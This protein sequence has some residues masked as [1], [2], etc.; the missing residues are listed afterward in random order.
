MQDTHSLD[1]ESALSGPIR[2]VTK[3]G[4][5]AMVNVSP[6]RVSQMIKAG[7]PVEHNGRIDIAR[8]KL[9]IAENISNTRS[10]A[11]VRGPDLF[12]EDRRKISLNDERS[13]LAKEQ[14]DAVAMRNEQL[15]RELVKASDVE[16]EWASILRKLRSSLLAVPSRTRQLLA[17]LTPHDVAVFDAEIRRALEDLAN[18]H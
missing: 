3:K 6:G 7:L 4:F 11:Q 17:H 12:G 18:D 10:N 8:G 13:R 1:I 2:S 9:W 14:A 16:R 5:A 15:R